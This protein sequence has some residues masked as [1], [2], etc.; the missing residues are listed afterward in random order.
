MDFKQRQNTQR[1]YQNVTKNCYKVKYKFLIKFSIYPSYKFENRTY[2]LIPNFATQKGISK[3][4]QPLRKGPYQI[5][6]KPTDV[7][8]KV[9]DFNKKEIVQ[10][11]NNLLPYYPKEYAL[12]ELTQLYYFTGLKVIQNSS[13]Q[14][15]NQNT[16]MQVI[17]KQL[18]K[19]E[20]ELLK[21]ISKN[22]DNKKIP[23]TEREN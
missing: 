2:V 22:V 19:K 20:K 4:L 15:Q 9:T 13:E 23:Q 8:Y 14:N 18:D 21:Q 6:D 16:D 10:H 5:I 11:Q 17:Q 3:N 7:T 12:R 1:N